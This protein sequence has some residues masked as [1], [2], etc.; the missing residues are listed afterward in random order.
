MSNKLFTIKYSTYT[1]TVPSTN[2]KIKFR[3]Y[4]TQEFELILKARAFNDLDA[5]YNA[6]TDILNACSFGVLDTSTIESTD[7]EYLYLMLRSK[8]QTNSLDLTYRC[9]GTKEDGSV[10][11]NRIGVSVN[12]ED[13]KVIKTEDADKLK[14]IFFDD[15]KTQGLKLKEPNYLV[16]RLLEQD[17]ENSSDNEPKPFGISKEQI[18]NCV[19]YIF[20]GENML[21]PNKDFTP[22]DFLEWIG[23]VP[24]TTL[25]DFQLFFYNLS[26]VGLR[27]PLLIKCPK[28]GNEE[29]IILGN[30]DNFLD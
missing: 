24:K 7:V 8:S 12:L 16:K 13:I 11:N 3:T 29:K 22:E 19:D 15:E 14:V 28:C 10:C 27:E 20:D 4:N 25:K 2:Q 26:R 17:M 5:E 9:Y 6:I 21:F 18:F 23:Q 1:F 30:F